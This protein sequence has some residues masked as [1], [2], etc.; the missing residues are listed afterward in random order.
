MSRLLSNDGWLIAGSL[1]WMLVLLTLPGL[2][3]T[4]FAFCTT[5]AVLAINAGS[6]FWMISRRRLILIGLNL[7]QIALFGFLSFQLHA[8]FGDEHFRFDREPRFY[9]WAE[10][11]L[12]HV[13]RAAD[14]LDA[15]DEY[16]IPPQAVSHDSAW[17]ALILVC[18]HVTVDVFLIGLVLRWV[19]RRWQ[20]PD[21]G[22]RLDQ[23]RREF[24][25]LLASFAVFVVFALCQ[26]LQPID[27]VL[28]PADNLLRLVDVGDVMQLSGWKLHGV[29]ENYWTTGAAMLFRLLAGI[30][31]ARLINLWRLKVFRTWGLGIDELTK[32]LDDPDAEM[33]SGA[34][35]GLGITG[36]G[37]DPAVPRLAEL[38][39]DVNAEVRY[40]AAWALG[41]I[42]PGAEA[43]VPNLMELVWT[44]DRRMR[45]AAIEALACMGRAA[46]PAVRELAYLGRVGDDQTCVAAARALRIIAPDWIGMPDAVARKPKARRPSRRLSKRRINWQY[47]EGAASLRTAKETG[48]EERLIALLDEGY[49]SQA[50]ELATL[51]AELAV[52]RALL[53]LPLLRLTAARKLRRTSQGAARTYIAA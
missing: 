16:G 19:S 15:L 21:E 50:R 28:W 51:Q 42:G 27:W 45:F 25:W 22:T 7:T 53:I 52:E 38:L 44:E 33:R 9:D 30:W 14:F 3:A 10:F 29:E 40:M 35:E 4:G 41:R 2:D 48:V 39:R 24:G 31:M 32:L 36:P 23:G 47:C 6:S 20:D 13:I 17:S 11:T 26:R 18:M 5:C 8:V 49:F 12:A 37:A 43:A 34:A 1:A 46:M